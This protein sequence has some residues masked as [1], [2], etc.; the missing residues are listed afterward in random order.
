MSKFNIN[1]ILFQKM[2]RTEGLIQRRKQ[3][4]PE[5]ENEHYNEAEVRCPTI[6]NLYCFPP[7]FYMIIITIWIGIS[8][9]LDRHCMSKKTCPVLY[10]NSLYK[11]IQNFLAIHY[12]ANM[13]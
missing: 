1:D 12:L 6:S 4:K 10:S 13:T 9:Y 8:K 11:I 3:P 2:D 5:A 7:Y